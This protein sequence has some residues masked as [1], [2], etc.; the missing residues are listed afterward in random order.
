MLSSSIIKF[1][2]YISPQLC[3]THKYV[4]QSGVHHALNPD[5]SIRFRSLSGLYTCQ[6]SVREIKEYQ[7]ISLLLLKNKFSRLFNTR[8]SNMKL[9]NRNTISLLFQPNA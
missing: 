8:E 4:H 6:N 7:Q 9:K 2:L 1:K 5:R 3:V